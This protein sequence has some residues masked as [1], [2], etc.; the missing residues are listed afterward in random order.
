[1]K[2]NFKKNCQRISVISTKFFGLFV[3]F[4]CL[5][6]I[7]YRNVYHP[8]IYPYKL[9]SWLFCQYL[10]VSNCKA[11]SQNETIA[12]SGEDGLVVTTQHIA[13]KV[14]AQILSQGGNA[15]DAA[16]AVGYALAVTDPCCGN[17]GGGGFML[18]HLASGEQTFLNFREKAPLASTSD[19]YLNEEGKLITGLSTDTYLAVGVPGTV[20]G[21]DRA[22]NRYGTLSRKQ[23]MAPAIKLAEKGFVLKPGDVKILKLAQKKLEKAD[24]NQF[25][26]PKQK[27][28]RPGDRLIQKDLARTLRLISIEGSKAF[29]QGEIA[30]SIVEASEKNEG[31]LSL[32]DFAKYTVRWQKPL[33]CNYRGY[34]IIT[35]PLPGGGITLCQMLNILEGYD[36]EELNFHSTKSLHLLIS[37]MLYAYADR[38][39][40][41]GDSTFVEVPVKRLLSK[42]YA[43]QIRNNISMSSITSPEKL[44]D[45]PIDEG[46][47]TTHYSITDKEG[48]AVA[49]T[50]TINSYFGTGLIASKTGFFL[51]N[52]MNDFTIKPG[53][54]NQFG[55]V[56]SEQN[57][58]KPEK[59]P[60]SSMSPTIVTKD[61]QVILVTGSPGGSTIPTTVL[62]IIV[63]IIDFGM[64]I[65]DAVSASRVHYQGLPNVVVTEP[66]AL[67]S[68]TYLELWKLGYKVIPFLSWGAAE[69]IHSD[70]IDNLFYGVNDPRKPAG[71]AVVP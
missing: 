68:E 14:G 9:G 12:V 17:I 7:I 48:N 70:P 35:A 65:E 8:L 13:S 57:S 11:D 46:S 42:S 28:L 20:L 27:L 21:L 18:I 64:N 60:L 58:I 15:I 51:N 63:N 69:S 2:F 29:Y 45:K 40:Y 16:V 43:T 30:S 47:N 23:V 32:E 61:G 54:P 44:Y 4:L 41:F 49:L 24:A 67:K 36:L 26:S 59:Q 55:L 5:D 66:Y 6:A 19:M 22:L 37:A 53:A 33:R 31:I 38:N 50:Y 62:Q 56:Q 39:T 34:E 1:M 10:P 52:Q 3:L 25:Y 71:K